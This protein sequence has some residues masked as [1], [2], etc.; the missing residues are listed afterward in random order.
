MR[1]YYNMAD[2]FDHP[3]TEYWTEE[4]IRAVRIYPAT[5]ELDKAAQDEH[6]TLWPIHNCDKPS[7]E[8]VECKDI[9]EAYERLGRSLNLSV[10]E[11]IHDL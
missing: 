11:R 4:Q 1:Y 2:T 3:E 5:P 7:W 8:H 10:H 6:S 9:D